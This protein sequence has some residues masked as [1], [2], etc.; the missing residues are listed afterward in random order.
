VVVA[1]REVDEMVDVD[2]EVGG[3]SRMGGGAVDG[4]EDGFD[5]YKIAIQDQLK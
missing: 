3:D 2:R 1:V 5:W 4:Y